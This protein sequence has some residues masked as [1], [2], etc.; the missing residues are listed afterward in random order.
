MSMLIHL[1]TR[2]STINK[3]SSIGWQ[4]K[5]SQLY[6][7][8]TVQCWIASLY[9]E[10]PA[11][12][13]CKTKANAGSTLWTHKSNNMSPVSQSERLLVLDK[14]LLLRDLSLPSLPWC[15]APFDPR[16]LWHLFLSFSLIPFSLSLFLFSCL[17]ICMWG[18]RKKFIRVHEIHMLY[19]HSRYALHRCYQARKETLF[20]FSAV[21][22]AGYKFFAREFYVKSNA[23]V[24]FEMLLT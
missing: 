7:F 4:K 8:S 2:I 22:T 18:Y 5:N 13:I 23:A 16:P 21:I 20:L 17:Y 10:H 3:W 6:P 1:E 9:R 11:N 19:V 14:N 15:D 12:Y 24:E